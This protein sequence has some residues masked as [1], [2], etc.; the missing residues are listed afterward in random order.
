V[1]RGRPAKTIVFDFSGVLF[2]WHPP[3]MIRREL[4]HLAADEP[5]AADWVQRIFEGFVGG[6]LDFDRGLLDVQEV[7]DR[8]V[9]RTGLASAEVRRVVDAVP[10]ELQPIPETIELLRR[11]RD[12]RRQLFFLSNMPVPYAEHLEREHDFLRWFEGGVISGREGMVKPEPSIFRLAAR[13][14]GRP[15]SELVFLD[16]MREN[17]DAARAQGWN[18]LHFVD[19]AQAE[20]DLR[21]S[22]WM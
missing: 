3:A 18:A 11:L 17:V 13:R 19:A 14:F 9:R 2:R 8:I 6:W 4:P 10:G 16:D 21:A 22:G 20:A 1:T 7:I 15:P 5:S 12:D